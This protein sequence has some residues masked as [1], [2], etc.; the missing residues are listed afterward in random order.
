[1]TSRIN[2]LLALLFAGATAF[3]QTPTITRVI[4]EAA[5]A[6]DLVIL[7]GTDL[8]SVFAVELRASDSGSGFA[9]AF[10]AT[11]VPVTVSS[12][13]VTF[14]APVAGTPTATAPSGADPV[15]I[16]RAQSPLGTTAGV[17]FLL[18]Q[19]EGD[20]VFTLGEGG[21]QSTGIGRPVT[22]FDLSAGVPFTGFFLN[23]VAIEL[24]NAIPGAEAVLLASFAGPSPSIAINDGLLAIDPL[25]VS[26]ASTVTADAFGDA[27]T[28]IT[29]PATTFPLGLDVVFQ[30]VVLDDGLALPYA[31]AK[32]LQVRL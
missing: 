29:P 2:L 7:E 13:R 14:I 11:V 21:D 20:E 6:G 8:A 25:S 24:E 19:L 32:G 18:L 28:L 3:A 12:D 22:S 26:V 16:V 23:P 15:G 9:F 4:P 5:S 1:M 27:S 17:P 31:L 30:Y 10:Q